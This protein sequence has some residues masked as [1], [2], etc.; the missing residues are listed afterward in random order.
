MHLSIIVA[1]D[2]S[3]G[4]GKNNQ[5]IWHLPNDLKHFKQLTTG[6]CMLMGRKNFES[7]GRVLPNRTSVII[8]RNTNYEAEGCIV[9]ASVEAALQAVQHEDEVFVIG[10]GEIYRQMLGLVSKIYLTLV[11]H[12]F[13]ADTFFPELNENEW[14]KISCTHFIADEKHQYNYS[15]LEYHRI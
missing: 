5:L 15:F 14:N 12:R 10:G 2:L 13:D 8:S 3:N 1:T 4:I 11:H 7:I 9:V 6:H